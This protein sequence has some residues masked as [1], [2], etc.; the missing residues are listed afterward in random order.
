MG[1]R[2]GNAITIGNFDGFHLGHRSIVKHTL[3]IADRDGLGTVLLTLN[4]NPKLFFKTEDRLIY[5]DIQKHKVLESSGIDRI[6][7]L[8]FRELYHLDGKD[9]ID[10]FL[11]KRFNIK[12]LVVGENFRLG[13]DRAWDIERIKGYG[14]LRNFNIKIVPSEKIDGQKVSSSSIRAALKKGELSRAN[15]M[16][17]AFYSINGEVI[18]GN[19]KGRVFG[20]PTMNLADENCILPNGVY[21]SNVIIKGNIY[22]SATYIGKNHSKN[23][24]IRKI[25][26]HVIEY[27]E[28]IYGSNI[29]IQF[30]K[31]IRK[32]K[33][34]KSEIELIKQIRIDMD[35]IK[36][37]IRSQV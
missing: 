35:S 24:N 26:T 6:E 10:I 12:Y 16:L 27:N 21:K 7:Y 33:K 4:P 23:V 8:K 15:K 14:S 30:L 18:R 36:F 29:E 31:F 2:I 17:G 3:K 25:E 37:D 32:E 22:K 5:T 13:R 34:F 20:F 11:I 9:F 19:R 28:D 1:K